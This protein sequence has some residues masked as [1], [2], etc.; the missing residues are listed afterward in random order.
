M[1]NEE[2]LRARGAQEFGARN[3]RWLAI[4]H[5]A[6]YLGCGVEGF[7]TNASP[8]P[9]TVAGAVIWS[10]SMLALLLVIAELVHCV[11]EMAPVEFAAMDRR[12]ST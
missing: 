2:L 6:F 1:C 10:I 12:T 5:S 7:A 3:S 4:A 8:T 11:I 9:V